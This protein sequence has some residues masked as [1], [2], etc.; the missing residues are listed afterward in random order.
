MYS[1]IFSTYY[2]TLMGDYSSIT[3]ITKRLMQKYV[4]R[5]ATVLELGCGT[6]NILHTLVN[7]YTLSGLDNSIHMLEQAKKKVPQA[8]FYLE[9]MTEFSLNKKF[10]CIICVFDTINHLPKYSQW[11]KLFSQCAKYLNKGGILLFDMNTEKRLNTLATMP[12][13]VKKLDRNT[14]SCAKIIKDNKNLYKVTF[15][16]FDNLSKADV[17]YHEESVTENTFPITQVRRSLQI[18]YEILKTADPFRKRVTVNTG[19][20]FFVCQKK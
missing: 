5:N 15:Q 11:E 8:T 10:D 13:Y 14:L 6:G 16:V 20:I 1:Q 2:D 4:P 18:H 3:S 9:D 12:A 19:R 7:D 17:K